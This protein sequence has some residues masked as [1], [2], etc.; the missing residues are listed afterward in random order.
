MIFKSIFVLF[1]EDGKPTVFS[2]NFF[3]RPCNILDE[4][5]TSLEYNVYSN[6][7]PNVTIDGKQGRLFI[8]IILNY[9]ARC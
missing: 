8:M 6:T 1:L 2:N 4:K 7:I 9:D 3:T 5:N